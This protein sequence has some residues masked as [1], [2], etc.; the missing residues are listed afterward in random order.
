MDTS[1]DIF[2]KLPAGEILWV[3]TAGSLEQ[4]RERVAELVANAPGDYTIFNP[5]SAEFVEPLAKSAKAGHGSS[6]TNL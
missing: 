2:C 5:R 4:A 3:E 1:Y 6:G